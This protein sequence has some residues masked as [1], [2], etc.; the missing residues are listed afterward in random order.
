MPFTLMFAASASLGAVPA[1]PQPAAAGLAQTAP[2]SVPTASET[3]VSRIALYPDDLI[4]IILPASTFPLQVVEASRYLDARAKDAKLPVKDSW[5]P[6]IK[7]LLNYPTVIKALNDDLDWMQSL[8]DAVTADQT[9]ML[10]AVQS[11]RRK[12]YTAGNLKTDEKQVVAM[13]QDIITIAPANPQVIY[14]PVYNPS[15]I[16][17][18]G[19]YSSWGYYGYGYP[20]YYYPYRPGAALATGLIWGA[21]IGAAWNGGHYVPYYGGGYNGGI[22]INTGDINIGTG[23]R[24]GGGTGIRP[25]GNGSAWQPSAQPRAAADRVGDPYR[26]GAIGPSTRGRGST[27]AST[28][29]PAA[30]ATNG[31]RGDRASAGAYGPPSSGTSDRNG[32]SSAGGYRDSA[33]GSGSRYRGSTGVRGIYDGGY[34]GSSGAF[35]GYGTSASTGIASARG[36]MSRSYAGG[37]GRRP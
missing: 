28:Y 5:D 17:V 21:A 24:V 26:G 3:L 15:T 22:R 9:S 37:G 30:S 19:G 14:V 34:G 36:R 25:G 4:A 35:A 10:E 31:A 13:N 2:V 23:D 1:S 11:Y 12:V 7:S 29:G 32:Y 20:S 33:G 16:M 27:S 6:A 8:G 18:Y